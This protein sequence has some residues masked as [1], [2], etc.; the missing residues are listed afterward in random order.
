MWNY[1]SETLNITSKTFTD[2]ASV[3]GKVYFPRLIL[4]LSKAASGVIKL[5]IQFALFMAFW[6]YYLLVAHSI[7]PNAYALLFPVLLVLMALLSTSIG[8]IIS[9]MTTK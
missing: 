7:T 5:L 8:I 2:N 3:F 4:P 1:F 9:S 6:F